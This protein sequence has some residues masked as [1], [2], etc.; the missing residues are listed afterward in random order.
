[1]L[2]KHQYHFF[3]LVRLFSLTYL[4]PDQ[5]HLFLVMEF[6]PGGDCYSLLKNVGR[7]AEP[8]AKMYIA[9]TLLAL[10]YLHDHGIVHRDLKAC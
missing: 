3:S 8:M 4:F 7:F 1:M 9:E 5:R 2:F 6:L 10:E